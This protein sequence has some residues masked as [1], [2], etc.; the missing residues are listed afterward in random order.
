MAINYFSKEQLK[1]LASKKLEQAAE[2]ERLSTS[3]KE[4]RESFYES[5]KNSRKNE[6]T[7]DLKTTGR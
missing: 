7:S 1:A 3:R 4:K 5:L 2:K 6:E